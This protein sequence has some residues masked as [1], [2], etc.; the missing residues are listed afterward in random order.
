MVNKKGVIMYYDLIEQL[1]DFNDKDFRE[2]I[3]A[4]M[5]YDQTGKE[6]QFDGMKKVAF[7]FI[8]TTIDKNNDEYAKK[9]EKNRENAM[10]KWG[11][12]YDD[13]EDGENLTLKQKNSK[14]RRERL[15]QANFKGTHTEEEWEE[16][17]KYFNNV[18]VKCG[19]QGEIVK[20]HIVPIYMGGSNGLGNIQP[21]C[22][23]CNSSKGKDTTDYREVYC[24]THGLENPYSV[25]ERSNSLANATDIDIDKDIDINI[26]EKNIVKK[27]KKQFEPPTL[28]QVTEYAKSKGRGDLASKFLEYY[29]VANWVDS[30]GNKVKNWK[31]KFLTW[32]GRESPNVT[33]VSNDKTVLHDRKY[34]KQE[35]EG[36]VCDIDEIEI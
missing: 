22:R 2:I 30:K 26:K 8:K 13:N 19:N 16:M 5:E 14:L 17:K 9:C 36:L 1:S 29:T 28:E 6:P 32:I 33:I 18:C 35:I 10:S 23:S 20:D 7:K 12:I 34:T 21:L 25:C 11:K 27:E 3:V 4:M 15:K 31:Q 24:L